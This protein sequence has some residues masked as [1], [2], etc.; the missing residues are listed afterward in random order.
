MEEDDLRTMYQRKE[1][2]PTIPV[3]SAEGQEKSLIERKIATLA[4]LMRVG[5]CSCAFNSSDS[6]Q[7]VRDKKRKYRTLVQLPIL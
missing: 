7:L 5:L 3:A 4:S 2:Q 6:L 1:Q